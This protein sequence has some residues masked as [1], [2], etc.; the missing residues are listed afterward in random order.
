M[1]KYLNAILCSLN[2]ALFDFMRWSARFVVFFFLL[3]KP[4]LPS[5]VLGPGLQHRGD[6]FAAA[7]AARAKLDANVEANCR[8]RA[9]QHVVHFPG[10]PGEANLSSLEHPGCLLQVA[11][12]FDNCL[13]GCWSHLA[14]L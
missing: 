11:L 14:T 6:P 10:R 7:E 12:K 2:V 13:K 8:K 3:S 5:T 1:L 9:H 4:W